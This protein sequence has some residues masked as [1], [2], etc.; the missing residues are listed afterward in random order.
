MEYIGDGGGHTQDAA[1]LSE[2][3]RRT[4][5]LEWNNNKG[6]HIEIH[7]GLTSLTMDMLY[8][9]QNGKTQNDPT[10]MSSRGPL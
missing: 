10:P 6:I 8:H 5:L 7:Q 9:H 2:I 3:L 1:C 4:R